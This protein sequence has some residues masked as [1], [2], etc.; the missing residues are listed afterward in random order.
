[1][2]LPLFPEVGTPGGVILSLSF[3]GTQY[4]PSVCSLTGG[5]K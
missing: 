4:V 3:H 2:P 1:M 5:V